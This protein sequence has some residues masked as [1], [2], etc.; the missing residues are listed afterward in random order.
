MVDAKPMKSMHMMIVDAKPMKAVKARKAM[1]QFA[2][3]QL[4]THRQLIT[5]LCKKNMCGCN[6]RY[7][8]SYRTTQQERPEA[9]RTA[10]EELEGR[11]KLLSIRT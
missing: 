4:M 8:D 3:P 11:P 5:Q 2:R 10:R 6:I 1:T 7:Y 9:S